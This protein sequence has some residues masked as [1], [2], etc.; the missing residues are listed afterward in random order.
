M[1]GDVFLQLLGGGSGIIATTVN[2][3]DYM[4]YMD[5]KTPPLPSPQACTGSHLLICRYGVMELVFKSG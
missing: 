4:V 3:S 5:K 2:H 1:S